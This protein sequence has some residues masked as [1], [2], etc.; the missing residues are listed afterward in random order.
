MKY[1]FESMLQE[2]AAVLEKCCSQISP[3]EHDENHEKNSVKTA[4]I[5]T[6]IRNLAPPEYEFR[7]FPLHQLFRSYSLSRGRCKK[8]N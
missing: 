1:E 8:L 3:G 5:P 6:E 7:K 2:Q 4:G